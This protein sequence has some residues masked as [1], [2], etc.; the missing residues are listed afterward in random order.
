[1]KTTK[2]V[3]FGTPGFAVAALEALH[4]AFT[5]SAVITQ[6]DRPAGRGKKLT[7]PPVKN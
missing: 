6:P 4:Q 5:V 1:M 7:A 2:I 3:F